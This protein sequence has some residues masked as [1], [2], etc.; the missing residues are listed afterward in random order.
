MA[1]IQKSP[2]GPQT[3]PSHS[4]DHAPPQR[5]AWWKWA[6]GL[7]MTYV[8]FGAFYVAKGATGF[9]GGGGDTARIVFFH[10]PA[11]ILSSV[12]YFV[13][14]V[15]AFRF[16]M[17]DRS[18]ETDAK[19]AVAMEL[20]F[21][22]CILATVTGSLFSHAQWGSYWNW[23]PR[24]TSIVVMLLIYAAYLALRGAV[25]ENPEKRGRLTAVYILVTIVPAVFLIW[26][27]P[28]IPALASLHP[29]DTL[30]RPANTS[31]DY[32]AVLYPSF[33]AFAMLFTWMF[34][35]RLR[36]IKLIMRRERARGYHG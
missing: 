33:L 35:L 4:A 24:Q 18:L 13:A 23:D 25:A 19:S 34:Q 28:R 7:L 9:T 31:A 16:L 8:C 32:K 26:V 20:G 36:Q 11:A 2:G 15:Y 12:A 3:S 1:T 17:R 27:V 5:L 6:C 14:A 22:F 10:V 21:L 29:P 30:A